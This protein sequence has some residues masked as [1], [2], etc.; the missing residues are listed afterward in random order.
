MAQITIKIKKMNEKSTHMLT[1]KDK[2]KE[3]S[4]FLFSM[5]DHCSQHFTGDHEFSFYKGDVWIYQQD[6]KNGYL[7]VRYTLVWEVF[8]KKYKLSYQQI[9]DFIYSWVET[10]TNWQG[11]TPAPN[12]IQHLIQVETNPEWKGLI[13]NKD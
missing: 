11:L 5:F 9:E 10:N 13:P 4:D 12:K 1:A 2:N 3:M 8:E 6:Y 7:W